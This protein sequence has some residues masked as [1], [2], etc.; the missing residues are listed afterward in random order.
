MTS[1]ADTGTKRLPSSLH[2]LYFLI[3]V[4]QDKFDLQRFREWFRDNFPGSKTFEKDIHQVSVAPR[5]DEGGEYHASFS[6]RVKQEDIEF[7]VEY[8]PGPRKHEQDEREPY[9]EELMQWL[10]GFFRN[11]NAH[12]HLHGRFE[13]PAAKHR[14]KFPLPFKVSLE[15]EAEIFG[16]SLRLPSKPEGVSTIRISLSRATWY[17]EAIANRRVVFGGF[18]PHG[19]AYALLST[20]NLLLEERTS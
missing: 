4:S 10:G 18:R 12:A 13:L 5:D 11:D 17:V 1:V 6:W 15:T 7:R 8:L 20:V 2:D 19:D 3:S 14:S 16:I 9:A